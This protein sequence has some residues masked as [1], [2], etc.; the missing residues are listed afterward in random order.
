MKNDCL[1][2]SIAR[3]IT[4]NEYTCLEKQ[5]SRD[6]I[7]RDKEFDDGT[8]NG[9][10]SQLNT[11]NN[12]QTLPYHSVLIACILSFSVLYGSCT[13]TVEAVCS[14]LPDDFFLPPP[15]CSHANVAVVYDVDVV[16]SVPMLVMEKVETSLSSLL[17]DVGQMVTMRERVD[18]ALGIS[19]AVEYFH[20]HLRVAHG[21]ISGDTVFVTQQLSAKMLDPSAAF[22]L[23]GNVCE[24][25]ATLADDIRQLV[26]LL[27]CLLSDICPAFSFACERL[28]DVAAG[29][30]S[31]DRKGD[32]KSLSKVKALL[33]D[34]RHTAEYSS[35]SRRRQ[36]LCQEIAE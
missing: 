27:L 2:S 28:R 17:Y 16:S 10:C 8:A 9:K 30:E 12:W 22:L 36:L 3:C 32:F 1:P 13:C 25:A 35:C 34:L 24:H 18:L 5:A 26:H 29:A 19:C 6:H 14:S 33:D 23:T 31:A 4:G 7:F 15:V 20:D 11:G 21:L